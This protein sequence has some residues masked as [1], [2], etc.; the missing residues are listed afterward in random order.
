MKTACPCCQC[1]TLETRGNYEICEVCYWEDDSTRND[2]E[3]QSGANGVSLGEGRDNYRKF[4]A[5]EESMRKHVRM[6]RPE[7]VAKRSV[8]RR[9]VLRW[10]VW[11]EEMTEKQAAE[12]IEHV[13]MVRNQLGLII[14]GVGLA[15][16]LLI[17]ILMKLQ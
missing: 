8:N 16:G 7:E 9:Q 15:V 11:R 3:R 17:S 10:E 14:V 4:G 6:P 5:C 12:L 13:A 2:E 1:L